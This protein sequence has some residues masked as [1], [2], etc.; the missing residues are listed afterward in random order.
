[1]PA[2]RKDS[3]KQNKTKKTKNFPKAQELIKLQIS[4]QT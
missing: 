1:M 2:G 4:L 3:K